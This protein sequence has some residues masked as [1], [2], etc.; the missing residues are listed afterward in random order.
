M[1]ALKDSDSLNEHQARYLLV[2]CQHIDKTLSEIEVIR[3]DS[4][5]QATFPTYF[6]DLTPVQR[7]TV[8]DYI[9]LIRAR[10][11]KILDEQGISYE[12][13]GIPVSKAINGKLYSI[14]IAAEELRPKYMQGFGEVSKITATELNGIAGE[15]RGLVT[16]L[17]VYI[18]GGIEQDF[19]SRLK[20]LEV[21]GNDM[22]LLSRIE[23]VVEERGLVEFRGVI[24]S[25]LDRAEDQNF[26]I[27]MFGRVS[28][29]KL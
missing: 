22:K 18:A 4:S 9:A 7:K 11:I 23:Q 6:S 17:N 1:T 20:Q 27:A 8:E 21:S 15:L 2:T 14:D 24:A 29:G 12:Q 16:K 19:K 28:S 26:E 10:L 3:N 5:S 25:I 13:H